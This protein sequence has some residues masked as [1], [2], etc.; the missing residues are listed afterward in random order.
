MFSDSQTQRIT[1]NIVRQNHREG[2]LKNRSLL[3]F[4]VSD[5]VGLGWGEEFAFLTS[6]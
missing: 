5:S 4:Q 2:V 6:S 1:W 3:P